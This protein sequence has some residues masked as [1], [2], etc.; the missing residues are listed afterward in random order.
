MSQHP[1]M[2]RVVCIVAQSM[3]ADGQTGLDIAEMWIS[4]IT[5]ALIQVQNARHEDPTAAPAWGPEATPHVAARRI[6]ARLLDAGWRP[7][8]AECLALPVFPAADL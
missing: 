6:I 1:D 8:D 4:T 3:Y 5:S 2:D 7:P